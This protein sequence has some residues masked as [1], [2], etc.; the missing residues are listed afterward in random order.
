[1]SEY[2]S[3]SSVTW[4][5][6]FATLSGIALVLLAV[7][8]IVWAF[9]YWESKTQAKKSRTSTQETIYE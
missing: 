1:M 5:Y 2:I 3:N 4:Q 8:C 9:G 7:A 6:I